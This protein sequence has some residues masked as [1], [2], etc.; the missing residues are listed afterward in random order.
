MMTAS[1]HRLFM[2]LSTDS[3]DYLMNTDGTAEGTLFS[4]SFNIDDDSGRIYNLINANDTLLF[5]V[6]SASEDGIWKSKGENNTQGPLSTETGD[7]ANLT[8]VGSLSY[9]SANGG[10]WKTNGFAGGTVRVT[11]AS[12]PLE[13]TLGPYSSGSGFFNVNG[14]LY[15]Q[16]DD[17]VHGMEPWISDGT[18]AGTHMVADLHPGAEG[19][20]FSQVVDYNGRAYFAADNG[21]DG[22]ELWSTDGTAAGTTMISDLPGGGGI[23]PGNFA[24][25]GGVLYFAA[26]DPHHGHELWR[27]TDQTAPT[28]GLGGTITYRENAAAIAIAPHAVVTDADSANFEDGYLQVAITANANANDRIRIQ[29]VGT[30]PGEIG[31]VDSQVTYGGV[32][33]GKRTGGFGATPLVV[34]LNHNATPAAVQALVQALAFITL[35]DAPSTLQRTLSLKVSDGDGGISNVATKTV[36][37]VA[38]N[39]APVLDNSLSPTLPTIA[40]DTKFPAGTPVWKLLSGAVQ[41]ADTGAKRGMAVTAASTFNGNWQFKL[42]GGAWQAMGDIA[43]NSPALLLPSD[44][45][46]RFIPKQDFHGAVKLFYRA[47][48]QTQGSSGGTLTTSGNTGGSKSMSTAFESASIIVTSV[49]D[50][51]VFDLHT[52]STGYQQGSPPITLAPDATVSDVDS[53]NFANGRLVVTTDTARTTGANVISIG[54]P[55]SVVNGDVLLGSTK[56]GRGGG[57]SGTGIDMVVVFNE[58]ATVSVV[59]QL[60]RALKFKS[61]APAGPHS[62]AIS[63]TDGDGRKSNV[64]TMTVNVIQ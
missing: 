61:T 45:Q 6:A 23:G 64:E 49:N 63:V 58:N 42:S 15:F 32:T 40:E 48:D 29:N 5:G 12:T 30:G 53:P 57:P 20:G 4:K 11:D 55:F 37:V 9:F 10:V 27:L 18:A 41:D 17:G 1:N 24:N 2:R 59:Q 52:D 44:A 25:V 26:E 43:S 31:V 28:L 50:A 46:V 36:N 3:G 38:V 34:A 14:T 54:G 21:T 22:R 19:S 62:V 47:W 60:V 13:F 8:S 33:I 16:A 7:I 35:G 56:I 39:D 51:P